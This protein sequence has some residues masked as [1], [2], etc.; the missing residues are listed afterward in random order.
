MPLECCLV[1]LSLATTSA[2]GALSTMLRHV[3]ICRRLK[4][5]N[6]PHALSVKLLVRSSA[7]GP[8][9]SAAGGQSWEADA[10]HPSPLAGHNDASQGG[11]TQRTAI[12]HCAQALID[13][14]GP[15]NEISLRLESHAQQAC[16]D[17]QCSL[18]S[19]SC[20]AKCDISLLKPA[21]PCCDRWQAPRH[22][23]GLGW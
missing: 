3:L 20:L 22:L 15:C 2:P 11:A 12:L 16:C 14:S 23:G 9:D 8:A 17:R 19:R 10:V 21:L 6:I 4:G 1:K 7:E 5:G 18:P 13:C